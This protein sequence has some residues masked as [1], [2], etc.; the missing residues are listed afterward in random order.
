MEDNPT[1]VS[2][3]D[4]DSWERE[5]IIKYLGVTDDI[6]EKISEVDTVVLPSYREGTPRTLLESGSMAK[7]PYSYDCL[8]GVGRRMLVE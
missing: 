2:K 7:T 4:V 3:D 6:R 5:G 1:A 8:A